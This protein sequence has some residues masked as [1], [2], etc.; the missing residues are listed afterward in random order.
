MP[1]A[2][3]TGIRVAV[4]CAIQ[5]AI[6]PLHAAILLHRPGEKERRVPSV[7]LDGKLD[8]PGSID[9]AAERA[10]ALKGRRDREGA[11]DAALALLDREGHVRIKIRGSIMDGA[12]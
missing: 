4:V 5:A 2:T 7:A 12:I 8:V 6:V 9:R 1:G 11:T 10:I 3:S